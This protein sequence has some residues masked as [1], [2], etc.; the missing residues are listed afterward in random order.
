MELEGFAFD[1]RYP[2]ARERLREAVNNLDYMEYA[3]HE[4]PLQISQLAA[5]AR[6]DPEVQRVIAEYG[7]PSLIEDSLIEPV[8]TFAT[9]KEFIDS[10]RP[11]NEFGPQKLISSQLFTM[12]R[13]ASPHNQAN[14]DYLT[15]STLGEMPVVHRAYAIAPEL[16]ENLRVV[17]GE[18][19]T[20]YR[21]PRPVDDEDRI[22]EAIM[23]EENG[24]ISQAMHMAYRILARLLKV[25]DVQ[26]MYEN[27]GKKDTGGPILN[28]DSILRYD[29]W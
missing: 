1:D 26:T 27:L 8:Q 20:R 14:S 10:L 24:D 29:S 12:L 5:G 19:K 9:D 25:S 23:R 3:V 4:G 13:V 18:F 28:A 22:Y 17:L 16:F 6:A 2:Q 15:A 11:I 7:W 21:D